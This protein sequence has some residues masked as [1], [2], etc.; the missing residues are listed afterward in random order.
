MFSFV[1][2]RL[3]FF[4]SIPLFALIFD[5]L[6][7]M[8]TLLTKPERLDQIDEIENE[9]LTWEDT[10]VSLHRF[11]GSQFNYKQLEFAHIHSNGLLDILFTQKI[12][13]EL[14]LDGRVEQHHVFEKSGWIS[15][16]VRYVED[17][18]YAL[19][20]LKLSY[21]KIAGNLYQQF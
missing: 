10:S 6:I 13:A 1:A 4:K 7:K 5:S 9:V 19:F 17:V 16:Y 20:L 8:W 14:M 11:G 21:N 12:K 3:S 18:D 2:R 15:F